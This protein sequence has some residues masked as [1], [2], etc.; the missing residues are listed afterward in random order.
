[1]G[2]L[3][4]LTAPN[5]K[6]YIGI[7]LRTFEERWREHLR[8]ARNN[9]Q[10]V[11]HKAIRKHGADNFRRDILVES[12]DWNVLCKMEITAIAK[13]R[14]FG[15]RG[16]NMTPG[17]DGVTD[18]SEAS[19]KLHREKTA[20]GTRAKW[21]DPEFRERR[22]AAFADPEV[23][24]KQS[25]ATTVAMTRLW[26]DPEFRQKMQDAHSRPECREKTSKAVKELWANSEYRRRQL[27]KRRARPPR[28]KAS[29]QAQSEKMKRLI[30]ERKAAGTY[31]KGVPVLSDS[32]LA[33]RNEKLRLSWQDPVVRAKRVAGMKRAIAAKK[34]KL[35]P[36]S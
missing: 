7:T 11:I 21:Q 16:Y 20:A 29:I 6:S 18:L 32:A 34:V 31:K 36:A 22:R 15:R 27:E 28:S 30:A 24:N 33:Q 25:Q 26:Q 3:Y 5:G 13:Y 2:C 12:D 10:N 14:T 9:S 35:C 1:M 19:K 23:R 17:G 8:Y 4:K